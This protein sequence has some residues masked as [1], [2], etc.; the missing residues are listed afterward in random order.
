MNLQ[1][2]KP[3]VEWAFFLAVIFSGKTSSSLNILQ[4]K[5][6]PPKEVGKSDFLGG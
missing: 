5:K 3:I 4:A 6:S 1:P 2:K